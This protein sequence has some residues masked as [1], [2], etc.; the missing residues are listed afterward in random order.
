MNSLL[1]IREWYAQMNSRY[2]VAID[3]A[4][5][6]LGAFLSVIMINSSIGT[7]SILKNPAVILAVCVLCAVLPKSLMV[8][9][10]AVFIV[11]HIYAISLETAAFVLAVLLI[12]FMLYF[13]FSA[14]DSFVLILLPV[15]FLLKIPFIIPIA[16]GLLAT[17]FSMVSAAFGTIVYFIID[18]ISTNKADMMAVGT[19]GL[20]IMSDMARKVFTNQSMYLIII[21]FS[22]VITTVYVIKKLSAPY[23]WQIAVGAGIVTNLVILIIGTIKFDVNDV[24]SMAAIIV[25][26]IV[27]LLLGVL[28]CFMVHNVDYTRTEHTQFEDDDYYYYVKAVPKLKSEGKGRKRRRR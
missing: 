14:G 17:P 15:L 1:K 20:S 28:I 12:M 10:L 4:V 8:L 13:R 11:A 26:D 18:Y 23:S 6:F 5:K 16:L 21:A 19:E 9:L 2:G 22:V 24:F 3:T 25:G 27:S 7:M